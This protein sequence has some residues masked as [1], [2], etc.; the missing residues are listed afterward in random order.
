MRQGD[1]QTAQKAREAIVEQLL[2][3]ESSSEERHVELARSLAEVRTET[4]GFP[5]VISRLQN[6]LSELRNRSGN[7]EDDVGGLQ[8][9]IGVALQNLEEK[10]GNSSEKVR[11]NKIKRITSEACKKVKYLLNLKGKRETFKSLMTVFKCLIVLFAT[12]YG[13]KMM[14]NFQPLSLVLFSLVSRKNY[15]PRSL[16]ISVTSSCAVT[17]SLKLSPSSKV[18]QNEVKSQ[19]R[20]HGKGSLLATRRQLTKNIHFQ[21]WNI[22]YLSLPT[23][24]GI[25][26][27]LLPL[28]LCTQPEKK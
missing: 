21:P 2:E 6:D 19:E 17:R 10:W 18:T 13:W 7:L 1:K 14:Y 5:E 28:A 8:V 22:A 24:A 20:P 23:F 27:S 25:K 9:R 12:K 4:S 15:S 26:K 11:K 3:E 16:F